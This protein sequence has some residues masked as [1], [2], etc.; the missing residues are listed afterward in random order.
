MKKLLLGLTIALCFTW[1][2]FAAENPKGDWRELGAKVDAPNIIRL[3]DNLT[4][5]VEASKDLYYT[6]HR[7]GYSGYAKI[8]WTGSVLDFSKK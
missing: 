3:T 1:N 8:T 5:G 4:I 2:V 7:D 6:G